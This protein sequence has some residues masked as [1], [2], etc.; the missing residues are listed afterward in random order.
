MVNKSFMRWPGNKS[1]YIKHI[2][3][4]LPSSYSCYIEPFVGSGALFLNVR[5][6]KWIIN[7]VNADL[8]N[9][10]NVIKDN[11]KRLVNRIKHFSV[12][13]DFEKLDKKDK[14]IE[15]RKFVKGFE[16]LPYNIK[17]ASVFIVAKFVAFMGYVVVDNKFDIPSLD[18]GIAFKTNPIYLFSQKYFDLIFDISRFL[19]IGDGRNMIS[20]EDYKTVFKKAKRNDFVFLDPP[21]Q[22]DHDYQFNY[23]KGENLVNF[24]EELL[25]QVEKLDKKGVKWLMTQADTKQVRKLFKDYEIISFKVYR[26]ASKAFKNE[27]IIKNY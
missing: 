13:T 23:N 9:V 15:A 20:N 27:L 4:H 8:I 2:M 1:R 11:P 17:R 19:N 16:G 21:Y 5:P 3:P 25:T 12:A 14:L 7:D 18:I 6:K 24:N 26:H 22:E 10:Y